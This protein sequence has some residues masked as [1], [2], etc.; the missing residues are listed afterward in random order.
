MTKPYENLLP[1]WLGRDHLT[2][3]F[4]LLIAAAR[5]APDD[6]PA[7]WER[8]IGECP[9]DWDRLFDLAAAHSM[10]PLLARFLR[11]HC[12]DA[13][14]P[15]VME[16][17]QQVV[18]N[19]TASSLGKTGELWRILESFRAE[20]IFA[21][22]FKGPTLAALLYDNLTWRQYGDLDLFL[23]R[24]DVARASELLH[25]RGYRLNLDWAATQDARF[26]DAAYALE[27][28]HP[29]TGLLVELHWELFHHSLAFGFDFN[30][31]RQ[32]AINVSPGGKPMV[33]LGPEDLLLYLCAHGAK[34]CWS[35][36]GW[37]VDVA[38]LI[39]RR[40][41]L[42]CDRLFAFARSQKI[43]RHLLLGLL[44]AG[45]LLGAQLPQ[46]PRQRIESDR[47]LKPLATQVA[48]WWMTHADPA[49]SMATQFTFYL[50]LQERLPD[51][52]R[53]LLRLFSTPNV[54][55]WEFLPLPT[56]WHFLYSVM[57]PI[58]LINK[59]V[60]L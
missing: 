46:L 37:V 8:V 15:A 7:D 39:E 51:K 3:E 45:D 41:D 48:E 34:H 31:L 23:D 13:V 43:E 38:R 53:Y 10:T 12:P 2:Q 47:S 55:D 57:R 56:R 50:K 59:Y 19:N 27:F 35:S 4:A 14:P 58:R 17:L 22:P 6:P 11:Q 18:A 54:G 5:I 1:V 32:R 24:G 25:E 20:G 60:H 44:L 40:G 21:I 30:Q 42:D 52:I 16:A 29:Q 26:Q 49:G 28:K 33:T 9:P 36:L